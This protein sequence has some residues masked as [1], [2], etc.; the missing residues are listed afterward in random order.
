MS[1][2]ARHKFNMQPYG[3]KSQCI[4]SMSLRARPKF[5]MQPYGD[6]SQCAEPYNGYGDFGCHFM[7]KV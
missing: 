7:L 1:L 6:K 5:N 2:R 3:D 4:A